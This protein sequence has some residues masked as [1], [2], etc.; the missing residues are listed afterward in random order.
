[1]PEISVHYQIS[2]SD[3]RK[4]SYYGLFLRQ[5]RPLLLFFA[6]LAVVV[7]YAVG[8]AAGLGKANPFV[9]LL[10]G[11]YL[12]WALLLFAGTEKQIRSYLRREDS[13]LGTELRITL[14]EKGL[15]MEI[16]SRGI[17][18]ARSWKQLAAV[19]ELND[20]F[21]FY[22]SGQDVYLLPKRY[23]SE[24]EQDHLRRYLHHRIA[25][26]FSSRFLPKT[27]RT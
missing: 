15:R 20:L 9:F 10:G 22:L 16:P 2:L 5:R 27:K 26:R 25:D 19:F 13:L 4:A 23:L 1:M 3:F 7:L 17:R 6:V 18:F 11:A 14:N 12:V 21:L 8:A 24:E